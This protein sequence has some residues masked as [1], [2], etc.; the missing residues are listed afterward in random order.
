MPRYFL[1]TSALVKRYINDEPG[2]A[3][4]TALC[5]PDAGNVLIISEAA[6]VEVVTTF[7]R[8]ARA[9]P[10]RLS[11]ADRDRLIG[12]FRQHDTQRNYTIIAVERAIYTRAGD[13]CTPH[14][15]RAYDAVQ[16]ACALTTRDDALA[17]GV[18]TPVFVCAD[19]ALLGIAA[20]EGMVTENPNDRP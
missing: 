19:V 3:W 12:L 5:A 1:D 17:A 20:A 7:C 4:V 6:L 16:L 9:Q 2:Y 14:P 11:A 18:T 8:M 15:L 13:L 10:P